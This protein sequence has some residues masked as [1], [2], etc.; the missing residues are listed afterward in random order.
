MGTQARIWLFGTCADDSR[1]GGDV[2]TYVETKTAPDLRTRLRCLGEW[3][4]ALDLNVD[5]NLQ[6]FGRN[7]PIHRIANSSRAVLLLSSSS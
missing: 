7:L 5:L 1:L 4:D 3:A 2:D 6:R